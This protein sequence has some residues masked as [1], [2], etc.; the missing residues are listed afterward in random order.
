MPLH[1]F[2]CI[3]V[4]RFNVDAMI[5]YKIEQPSTKTKFMTSDILDVFGVIEKVSDGTPVLITTKELTVAEYEEEVKLLS[6][7]NLSMKQIP[8]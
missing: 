3:H 7:L 5:A 1:G 6:I 4:N 8:G 2:G